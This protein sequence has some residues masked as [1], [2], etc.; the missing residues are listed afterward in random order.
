M[1]Q[2][3]GIWLKFIGGREASRWSAERILKDQT[4]R[5]SWEVMAQAADVEPVYFTGEMVRPCSFPCELRD[6]KQRT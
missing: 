4:Q 3:T 1:R 2:L 5:F 6:A